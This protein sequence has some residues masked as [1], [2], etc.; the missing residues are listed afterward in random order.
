[1]IYRSRSL[2]EIT[3]ELRRTIGSERDQA[4]ALAVIYGVLR[5]FYSLRAEARRYFKKPLRA[6]DRD[7]EALVVAALYQA[8]AM[9]VPVR[10]AVSEAVEASRQLGK[11]WASGMVNA[12]TR[13]AL[14]A[15]SAAAS[16][17]PEQCWDHPAWLIDI[18]RHDWP[19][20]WQEI[21]AQNN[22]HP[23]M[24]LRVNRRHGSRAAYLERLVA[25]GIE[26]ARVGAVD[27]AVYLARPVN[28]DA[29]PGFASGDVSVQDEAA[30][31][32]ADL[33]ALGPGQRILDACAAPGGKTGHLLEHMAA[34]ASLTALEVDAGRTRDL[35]DTVA[36]LGLTCEVMC[37]D[38]AVPE[39]WFNGRPFDRILVDAP[40]SGSGVI[41]RHPDIRF[42]RREDD[43]ARYRAQQL[44]LLRGLWPL[45]AP[46]GF[47][48]YVTCSIFN[49][50][51]D[52]VIDA[53]V[54][55]CA[56][57]VARRPTVNGARETSRGMQI[58]PGDGGR[59]GF[60]FARLEKPGE[61][62]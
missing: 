3:V 13:K 46:G 34:D 48:L 52:G 40:C 15:T 47:L 33:M 29:L 58:L 19:Q 18:V 11:S 14:Q 25:A 9:N 4:F 32:V 1:M 41:R 43:I 50:E 24:T 35:A 51:N 54:T 20:A 44:G 12:V 10:A 7:I 21:L 27:D 22:A 2:N 38:A 28:V 26:V 8:R 60:Y 31:C 57:C 45:L 62:R 23:P 5:Q 17:D 30:Q 61:S 6:R 53:F 37:A 16:D 39:T 42:H 36:R 55:E 49:A 59:D 56:D